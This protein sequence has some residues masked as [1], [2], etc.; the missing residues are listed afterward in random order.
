MIKG[1]TLDDLELL[2]DAL[3]MNKDGNLSI[4]EFCLCI[5]GIQITKE[6]RL[7][8][9]DPDLEKEMV[10]QIIIL[11]NF[12]D[13]NSD[14]L[15]TIK[16]LHNALRSINPTIS[17]V[18]VDEIMKQADK[19]SSQSID[20]QEF[21]NLMLPRFKEEIIMFESNLEDLRRLF[22]ESDLDHSNYLSKQELIGALRKIQI[23]LTEVQVEELMKELDLNEN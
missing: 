9:F 10:S 7:K 18:Q 13:T 1:V 12:F 2:F 22:K 3:D 8:C 21:V 6:Q 16:E 4:N 20:K 23:E 17:T 11:F 15:I 14:G 19:N 5:E